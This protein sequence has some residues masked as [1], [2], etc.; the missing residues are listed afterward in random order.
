MMFLQQPLFRQA[1]AEGGQVYLT[2]DD[3]PDPEW[4]PRILDV[5]GAA[6]VQATFFIIGRQIA[7]QVP[8][9]ERMVAEGHMIGNHGWSHRHPWTLLPAAARQ[10]VR[11]GTQAIL[12]ALATAP[13]LFRP[14]H[15]RLHPCM[16]RQA[17]QSG[18]AVVLWNRTAVDWGPLGSA[19]GI[20]RRLAKTRAGDIV[21]MHD[22][23]GKSNH[24]DELL[25]VLPGYL[26]ALAASKLM[27]V[28]L[29]GGVAGLP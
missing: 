19:A 24:P 9:L 23:A 18:Q 16:V 28:S 22:G 7:T 5:L 26:Q 11:S 8:L 12:E 29:G 4:T 15:G 3:G 6:Q 21:L 1:Q 27:A 13:T 17:R 10:E 20:A 25:A 2:F 14:A